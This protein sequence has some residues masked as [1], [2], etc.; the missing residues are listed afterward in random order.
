MAHISLHQQIDP[1]SQF[2]ASPLGLQQ[3][4]CR[5][6]HI[7]RKQAFQACLTQGSKPADQYSP[8]ADPHVGPTPSPSP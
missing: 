7:K 6:G 8:V 4:H 1:L 2:G 3:V 5:Q